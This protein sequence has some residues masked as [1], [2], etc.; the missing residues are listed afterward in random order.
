MHKHS[1]H[2]HHEKQSKESH[3]DG[4]EETVTITKK[5]YDLLKNHEKETGEIREKMLRMQADFENVRKRL[6]REKVEFIKYADERTIGD[7]IPFVDDFQRAFSAADKTRDFNVLHRG[8]EMILNHL[9]ALLKEKGVSPIEAVGALFNPAYHEAM[10]QVESDEYPDNTVIEELQKGYL[11]NDRVV[12]TAKVK[13][14]IR[15]EPLSE[16]EHS[17]DTVLDTE[18]LDQ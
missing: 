13:V 17:G 12:R 18:P 11:L 6:D 2:A 3:N 5:E 15:K 9:L 4:K 10:L 8:V 16:E 14:S 7:L 1:E